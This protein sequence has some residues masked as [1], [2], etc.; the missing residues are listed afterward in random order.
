MSDYPF[1][2]DFADLAKANS[3]ITKAVMA[4]RVEVLQAAFG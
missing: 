3:A 2:T 1:S 4:R